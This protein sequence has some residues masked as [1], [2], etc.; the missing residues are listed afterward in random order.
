[1]LQIARQTDYQTLEKLL[2]SLPDRWKE[3]I[4]NNGLTIAK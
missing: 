1:M 4:K 3:V 2:D